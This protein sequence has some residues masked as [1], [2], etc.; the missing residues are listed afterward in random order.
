[1]LRILETIDKQQDHIE[2]TLD[3]MSSKLGEGK[4]RHELTEYMEDYERL[5]KDVLDFQDE[6]NEWNDPGN[7]Q[8]FNIFENLN[9]VELQIREM[10]QLMDVYLRDN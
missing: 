5:R 3:M 8:L 1:M 4:Y 2:M 10:D 7:E 9:Q 6:G